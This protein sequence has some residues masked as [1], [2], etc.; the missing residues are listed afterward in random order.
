[1]RS[2][3]VRA[4]IVEG[5]VGDVHA[6]AIA[7]GATGDDLGFEV[8]FAAT[9]VTRRRSLPSSRRREVPMRAASM[10]SGWGRATRRAVTG[11]GGEVEAEG[12]AGLEDDAA[13]LEAADAE[14]GALDVG[15]DADGAADMFL[16]RADHGDAGQVVLVGAVAE[17]EAEDVGAGVGRGGRGFRG[18][19]N[20]RDR[21][22]R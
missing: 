16:E 17:V 11:D 12:L 13:G 3:A 20:W 10:I 2:F 1:M 21:G 8:V 19:W 4:G 9:R 5:D 6:F 15:E 22:L 18:C 7:E 14:F